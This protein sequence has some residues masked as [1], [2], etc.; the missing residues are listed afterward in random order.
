MLG[1][2]FIPGVGEAMDAAV[3]A[4]PDAALW[5]KGLAILSLG[6]NALTSGALPNV[7]AVLGAQRRIRSAYRG[8]AYGRMTSIPGVLE[9]HH[10]P[11]KSVS[12]H[13]EYSTPA[14][15]MDYADHVKTLSHGHSANK[16]IN[17][18]ADIQQRIANGDVRGAMAREV[19]DVRRAA[20]RNG[21]PASKYN[22][23]LREALDYAYSKGMLNK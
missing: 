15:Q 11:A 6:A 14:V 4:D 8:G 7:G 21:A 20:V 22:Y 18:R 23:G 3:V 12:S 16:G 5:E 10:I 13:T 1:L 2:S 9:R 19:M 17:F